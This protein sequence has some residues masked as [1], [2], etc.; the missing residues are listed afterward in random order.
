MWKPQ[1]LARVAA[2]EP[3]VAAIAQREQLGLRVSNGRYEQALRLAGA[4]GDWP[5]VKRLSQLMRVRMR[6]A[7]VRQKTS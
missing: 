6:A 3:A 4:A 7:C 1:T 2:V 5:A